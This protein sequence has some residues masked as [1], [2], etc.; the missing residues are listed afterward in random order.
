MANLPQQFSSS[1]SKTKLIYVAR[2]IAGLLGSW[3][4]LG[5][6][7]RAVLEGG[8]TWEKRLGKGR[9]RVGFSLEGLA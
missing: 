8:I 4:Q 1:C 9:S 2:S 5:Q 3:I 6:L 7:A